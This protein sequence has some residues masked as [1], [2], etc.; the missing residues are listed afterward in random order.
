MQG[1]HDRDGKIWGLGWVFLK[2]SIMPN[3]NSGGKET[4]ERELKGKMG[5]VPKA[6]DFFHQSSTILL[7]KEAYNAL[8][9]KK[10]NPG[11]DLNR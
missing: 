5:K 6:L 2:I 1:E 11:L 4:L 9:K 8:K 10:H 3:S 7:P